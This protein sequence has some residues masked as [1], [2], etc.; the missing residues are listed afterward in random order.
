MKPAEQRAI[1]EAA[2]RFVLYMYTNRR[3]SF[4]Q[5]D[6]VVEEIAGLAGAQGRE[7]DEL[8]IRLMEKL[9]TLPQEEAALTGFVYNEVLGMKEARQ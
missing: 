7:A 8:V 4:E 9:A 1:K 5:K 3:S 6:K 2:T